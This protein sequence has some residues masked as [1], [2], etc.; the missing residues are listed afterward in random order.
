MVKECVKTSHTHDPADSNYANAVDGLNAVLASIQQ[1]RPNVLWENCEDGGNMMTF[2]MVKNYVTSITNDASGSLEARSA[3]FGATYPFPPRY[4]ERYM[5]ATDG[6]DSY[7]VNSYM[8]GGPWVLQN[9]LPAL[10]SDQLGFLADQIRTYKEHRDEIAGA[11]VYHIQAPSASGTD[12][13]QSY[14]ATT[15]SAVAVVTRADSDGQWYLFK[16]MGLQ[17]GQLYAVRF[18]NSAEMYLSTG[19]QLMTNGILVP[20][21]APYSSEIVHIESR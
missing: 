7:A 19:D 14:N 9:R 4:A 20:L 18:E 8:F 11:K 6:L 3:V 17:P 21:P 15:N 16:P 10:T 1:A 12:A 5:P 13:I 2:N